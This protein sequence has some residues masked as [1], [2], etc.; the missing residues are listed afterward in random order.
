VATYRDVL[1]SVGWPLKAVVIDFETFFGTGYGLKELSS[2][3][4]VQDPRFAFVSVSLRSLAEPMPGGLFEA[5][6]PAPKIEDGTF[7]AYITQPWF[8]TFGHNVTWMIQNARFDAVVMKYKL[9]LEPPFIL[10]LLD[11]DRMLNP[12]TKH[13]LEAQAEAEGLIPKGDTQQFKGLHWEDMDGDKR[14][15]LEEYNIRDVRAEAELLKRKIPLIQAP[16]IEIPLMRHTLKMALSPMLRYDAK[17]AGR[18]VRDMK[19]EVAGH[20]ARTG[21][22]ETELRS[23]KVF[24]T[25]L[26]SLLPEGEIVPMKPGAKGPILA[27]AKD[28]DGLK[29]LLGH[30][31]QQVRELVEARCAV[32]SW[33]LHLQRVLRLTRQA[34]CMNGLIWVPLKY[35]G[36]HTG[37]WSGDMKINAQNLGGKGRGKAIHPLI[38]AMRGLF[39]APTGAALAICDLGQIEARM[40]AWMAGQDSLLQGFANGEDIYSAFASTLFCHEVRKPRKD[41][42]PVVAKRM[43]IERGFGKD[44][45]LGC[46]YGMG[47]DKFFENCRAND[48]LRPLFDSGQYDWTFIKRLIDTY[49]SMYPKIP[50][51]WKEIERAFKYVTKYPGKT[52]EVSMLGSK[53]P[54]T[55]LLNH[56][57]T[58]TTITLPSG[59]LLSYPYARV[60]SE[61]QITYRDGYLWGGSITENVDQAMSRDILAPAIL[62]CERLNI[63]VVLH[64]HD[65]LVGCVSKSQAEDALSKMNEVMC[66]NPVWADGLPLKAEGKVVEVY[67]K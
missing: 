64:C 30:K 27:L 8:G 6:F 32:K 10:D 41:D 12:R 18:L 48:S 38:G 49:R 66:T 31:K 1:K 5:F 54:T 57:G 21:M 9:G 46:G 43:D 14:A 3:E 59:R 4:Y 37:R 61:G 23:N 11:I 53:K 58:T 62:E 33:P 63:P 28:D 40:L 60:D 36:A 44:A 51:F 47:A 24:T 15:A 45:I 26:Q 50:D 55:I 25:R 65:E 56:V 19:M 13:G 52:T 2:I 16:E 22:T 34:K 7:K 20:L 35:Y 67:C 42:D 39:M 17:L 29:W